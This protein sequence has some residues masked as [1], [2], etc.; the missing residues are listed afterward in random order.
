MI[1]YVEAKGLT[2]GPTGA[3]LPSASAAGTR[4][5]GSLCR[6]SRR[7][8]G[9]AM[10][11]SRQRGSLC[12]VSRRTLGKAMSP[13]LGVVTTSFLYRVLD[14]KYSTKQAIGD[15]QLAETSLPRV[16]SSKEFTECFLESTRQSNCV[17]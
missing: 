8:L 2:K 14:K 10:S 13:S 12:R 5:R 9:K 7:T 16:T 1:S 15:V 17:W 11:P 6:V 3:F 4:Q